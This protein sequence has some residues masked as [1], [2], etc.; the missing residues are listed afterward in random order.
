M[1]ESK[2]ASSGSHLTERGHGE[3]L[4]VFIHGWSCRRTDWDSTL[5]ALP[6][7]WHCLAMDLPGHGDAE[8]RAW[9]DWTI[10]GLA[11]AVTDVADQCRAHQLILVG[12]SMGGCVALEAARLWSGPVGVVLVD[13]FGLPY[14][15]MDEDTIAAIEAPF[16]ANF[17]EAMAA[18]VDNTTVPELAADTREWIKSRMASGDPQRLL[19]IWHN[20]LR[21]TPEAAFAAIKGPIVALNGEHIPEPAQQRCAPHVK[22]TVLA[23]T[24]HFP[25]FEQ[26]QA[27]VSE[28]TH[29]LDAIGLHLNR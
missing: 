15:D 21:W 28:L 1:S 12:H 25:L 10:P 22:E 11:R 26:P 13:T 17:S 5:E 9:E 8:C 7:H 23:G 29:T 3:P 6:E 2:L 19:P 18:L 4:V 14:G 27:F 20:L 16:Q 24:H